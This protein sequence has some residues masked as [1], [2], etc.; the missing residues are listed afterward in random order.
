MTGAGEHISVSQPPKA[1]PETLAIRSRPERAIRFKRGVVVGLFALGSVSLATIAWVALKPTTFRMTPSA[2]ELAEA[3]PRASNDALGTLPASY[4][5]APKLGPPLP[6]DLGRPILEHQREMASEG[7]GASTASSQ[8]PL[9]DQERRASERRSALQSP[10]LVQTA[11]GTTTVEAQPAVVI[12]AS[13]AEAVASNAGEGSRQ[14]G[15]ADFVSST[16]TPASVDGH[17]MTPSPSPYTLSAGSVIAASLITGLNSDVPGL[18]TAQVTQNCFDTAS[19]QILLVPQGSRLIGTYDSVVAFGQKR[20]LVIWQRIVRPDGSSL[21]IDNLPA[22]DA[23]GYA[24]LS[25]KVDFH[26]WQLLK[27]I[28]LST[29]LGIGTELSLSGDSDLVRAIRQSTQ[30]NAVRAGDQ[31]VSRNLDVQ[32][33]IVIRPG[34]PVRLLVHKDL[35]LRPWAPGTRV[36]P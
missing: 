33:T 25:D 28:G 27:G 2:Q 8:Q 12:P 20:A 14:G 18:V 19:G 17:F 22:T 11:G 9:T 15:K 5:N 1:D 29:L 13:S 7:A 31:I 26:T 3:N 16:K 34:S 35:V 36:T 24:G 10:L 23:A 30:Q 4:G 32:P 21:T 6:G